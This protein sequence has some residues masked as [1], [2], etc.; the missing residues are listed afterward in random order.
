M[1]KGKII[2]LILLALF[3]LI[4]LRRPA[5]NIGPLHTSI[6]FETLYQPPDSVRKILATSC[7]DCH[8]DST[9]YPWYVNVQPV[10]WLMASH[11]KNGK[12]ELN[13]SQFASYSQ[14]RRRAKLKAMINQVRDDEMPL[15]SYTFIHREGKLNEQEKKLFLNWLNMRADSVGKK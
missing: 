11:I 9:R 15:A 4:Q 7:Y 1:K 6:S 14:R 2:L 10:G 12:K 8:S 13:F 3:F 5:K